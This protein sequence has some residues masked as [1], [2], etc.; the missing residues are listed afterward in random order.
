M[1]RM[2]AFD[3][4]WLVGFLEGEG[5]FLAGPPSAPRSTRVVA[6]TTDKDVA[7]RAAAL[8][9]TVARARPTRQPHHKLQYVIQRSGRPAREIMRAL[10]PNMSRRRQAA[11]ARALAAYT[12]PA[13]PPGCSS[14]LTYDQADE[15]RALLSSG[16]GPTEAGRRFGV[17]RD[18]VRAVRR[19]YKRPDAEQA[20]APAP[21][22][23]S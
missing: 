16:V 7:E 4:G 21:L 22:S 19:G 12:P 15:I 3:T 9:G 6:V 2:N 23:P 8:M 1:L 11:I 13:S 14:G 20:S 17:S 5:C 10:H 18:V